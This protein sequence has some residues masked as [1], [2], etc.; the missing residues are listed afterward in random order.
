M[1]I[2]TILIW[3]AIGFLVSAEVYYY[4]Y[5]KRAAERESRLKDF[6]L[7]DDNLRQHYLE[8]HNQNAKSARQ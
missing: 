5:R 4:L 7:G 1:T 2:T 3:A 6:I 8:Y